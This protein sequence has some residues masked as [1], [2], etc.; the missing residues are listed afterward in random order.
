MKSRIA[1]LMTAVLAGAQPLAAQIGQ[2]LDRAQPQVI[3]PAQDAPATREHLVRR[4]DTLWDLANSYLGNPFFWPTI[5]EA[6]LG[7]IEDPHWIYPGER[8][9]IPGAATAVAEGPPGDAGVIRAVAVADEQPLVGAGQGAVPL[10]RRT[11]FYRTQ[12]AD[13]TVIEAEALRQAGVEPG[14]HYSAPWL[15]PEQG[16]TVIGTILRSV[17]APE[18][19]FEDDLLVHPF[20][21]VYVEYRGSSRP[22]VGVRLMIADRERRLEG[23]SRHVF[24][25]A[26]IAT[27]IGTEAEVM[28]VR[29]TEQWGTIRRGSLVLPL[30]PFPAVEGDNQPLA[31]GPTGRIIGWEV[32]QALYGTS[33]RGFVNLGSGEVQIGDVLLAYRPARVVS[34]ST[35]PTEPVAYVKIVR[36]EENSAT[37]RVTKVLQRR[38]DTGMPL[39]VVSRIP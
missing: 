13:P 16:E 19:G 11:R 20:D 35:V 33:D 2:E 17:D 29:L 8:L 27:V 15:S 26:G 34:G 31:N 39:Q 12:G 38:L 7:V 37:F 1:T 23:D 28:R 18:S 21:E 22:G 6:N 10:E 24:R 36:V 5:H 14:E 4:G 9:V 32:E 25:P 3:A 30:Q